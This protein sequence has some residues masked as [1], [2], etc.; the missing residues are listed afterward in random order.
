MSTKWA[1]K[2]ADFKLPQPSWYV[3]RGGGYDPFF[4]G[5]MF[6]SFGHGISS[7]VGDYYKSISAD[8][9]GDIGGGGGGGFSGGGFGGGGG[10]S[11]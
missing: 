7:S 9:A 5:Y 11:W 4:H 8:I 6:S 3:G 2:F 10:G 1:D